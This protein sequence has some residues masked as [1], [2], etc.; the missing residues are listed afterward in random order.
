[1]QMQF[2]HT[3]GQSVTFVYRFGTEGWKN[4]QDSTSNV[5]GNPFIVATGGTV[6]CCGD[7]KIHTFTGPGTFTVT[8]AGIP[9]NSNS[10]DYLVVAGGGGGG[11]DA[12]TTG[13]GGGGAGGY[14]ESS[15]TASGCYTALL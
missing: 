7:Y 15:G 13:S 6:T 3:E 11:G 2:Y 5:T 14:R 1:M 8:S 12:N 10:V 4:V 9:A